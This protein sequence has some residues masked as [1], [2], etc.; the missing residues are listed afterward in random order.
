VI[1]RA[2]QIRAKVAQSKARASEGDTTSAQQ[3]KAV[4]QR[5]RQKPVRRTVD[6][7][8]HHHAEL[9]AWCAET[10]RELGKARITGQAVLSTLVKRLLTDETLARKIRQDL[11]DS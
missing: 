6:L 3:S 10:A 5:P 7:S 11:A 1:S 9:D 4:F 8:P 2:E